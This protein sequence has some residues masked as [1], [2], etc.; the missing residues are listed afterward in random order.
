MT[1]TDI[2]PDSN[3]QH[4]KTIL[5]TGPTQGL[6][7]LATL[8]L[9]AMGCRLVLLGRP[10]EA[11][12]AIVRD[13]L[14]AGA[15]AV[16]PVVFDA[17][18]LRS[19]ARAI[20]TVVTMQ[21]HEPLDVVVA[22]AGIQLGDRD[23][24]SDDGLELTFA[25]NVVSV[26]KLI[27]GISPV[28]SSNAHI[29]IVG[30]GTHFGTFPTT[31]LVAGP[32]WSAI[33]TIAKPGSE[34]PAG[35]SSKSAKAG[36]CAYSTSKLAVNYLMHEANRVYGDR[37]RVNVFDPGMMPGTGLARDLPAFKRFAWNRI[38]PTLVPIIPGAS[39]TA[40]SAKLL[41]SLAVGRDHSE[42]RNAYIEIDRVTKPS[43]ASFDPQRESEL[44]AFC[45]R[46]SV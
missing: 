17:A 24:R 22:N 20:E 35:R 1:V 44:W 37:L 6:G 8:E 41:A 29:V 31:A 2:G 39:K 10:S 46:V 7:R 33:E 21:A 27:R 14:S 42:A 32:V 13:A 36:Q 12:D 26:Q 18:S 16:E 9:A 40:A 3:Q 23:H 19:V 5:V 30:S 11:F 4:G 25:V 45:E 28:L 34:L 43:D 15:Q 38:L